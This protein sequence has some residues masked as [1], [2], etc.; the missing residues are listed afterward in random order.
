MRSSVRYFQS[1]TLI[2]LAVALVGG[3]ADAPL[4]SQLSE[5]GRATRIATTATANSSLT[6]GE[7]GGRAAGAEASA[8]PVVQ[9]DGSRLP[10]PS[11]V[12]ALRQH[13]ER[14]RASKVKGMPS[15]A[16]LNTVLDAISAPTAEEARAIAA[17]LPVTISHEFAGT[18]A[19]GRA[20]YST[21]VRLNDVVK[22]QST[23]SETVYSGAGS[24]E[25]VGAP[26]EDGDATIADVAFRTASAS[27]LGIP[28]AACE[29]DPNDPC[30]TQEEED[31]ILALAVAAQ[32]DLDS[33]D[34]A[35]DAAF[36]P[37]LADETCY[38]N[39][40]MNAWGTG[41][42]G[43]HDSDIFLESDSA[44]PFVNSAVAVDCETS[45]E[46]AG[47]DS[48][49]TLLVGAAVGGILW[50]AS[51]VSGLIAT[52]VSPEPVSKFAIFAAWTNAAAGVSS[53]IVAVGGAITCINQN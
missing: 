8:D 9:L 6:T 51:G 49:C 17:T 16:L 42:A 43:M 32:S 13:I 11:E 50:A 5:E 38:N 10:T 21:T 40:D 7:P 46:L 23:V 14:L 36:A 25:M 45:R 4:P 28:V 3:C 53:A 33:L 12:A 41:D 37:C 47:A 19:S 35:A 52:I 22:H 1:Q 39:N 18:S 30:A 34:A 26:L 20:V 27:L 29:S 24:L 2:A 15:F 44:I 31:Y 48:D